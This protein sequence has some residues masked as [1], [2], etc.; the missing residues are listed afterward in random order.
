[1]GLDVYL[2][3]GNKFNTDVDETE[4][5]YMDAYIEEKSDKYPD[6]YNHKGYLRSSYND[7]GYNRVVSNTIGKDL[8][9]IF[10]PIFSESNNE[11]YEIEPKKE[12][13]EKCLINA[14][15]V[16]KELKSS[17]EFG[18]INV[19]KNMFAPIMKNPPEKITNENVIKIVNEE[20]EKHKGSSYSNIKGDFFLDTPLEVV[21]LIPGKD[22]LNRDTVFVVHK[23]S[24]EYYIQE[25][26]IAIE[27]IEKALTLEQ[28]IVHWSS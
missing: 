9:Y 11:S 27:F 21:A 3:D 24:L 19:S 5:N 16:L 22:F 15:E 20:Y 26:E 25:T 2:L 12:E 14:Q 4:D 17:R 6:N 28:P 18:V 10:N 8:Y 1:M 13:L 7:S 23:M